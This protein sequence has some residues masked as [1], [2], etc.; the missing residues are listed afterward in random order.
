MGGDPP[1]VEEPRTRRKRSG[2]GSWE[3]PGWREGRRFSSPIATS[4]H[5]ILFQTLREIP[6][7]A[8]DYD[9]LVIG[10]G[11][12]GS[13]AALRLVEKG[14]S[15]GVV[16]AGRRWDDTTLP[17]TSW[18]LRRFLWFP[19]LGLRG[20]QRLTLLSDTMALS[21]VGVGGGS[22]VW[23]NVSYEPHDEAFSDPQWDGI[24]NWKEEL[25]P[26]YEQARRMLGV[27][28]NP[29]ETA[30]DTVIRRVAEA[31]GVEHTVEPTPV[32][33]YFG[34]PDVTVPDPY[35]GG[36][37]PTRTGC[38][39]CGGCMTGC[40][41]NA[42][43]RL[44]RSYLY[45]AEHHGVQV[46]PE[47]QVVDLRPLPD[48]GYEVVT[49]RPGAWI[50]RR[51]RAFTARQVVFSAGA[52]GTCKLLLELRDTGRLRELSSRLGRN[53]RTNS[54]A[55]V[56][57]TA[58][59]TDVD[60][61]RG[62]AISSSFQPDAHTH[63]EPVRYEKGSNAMGLLSTIMVDGGG[64][65]PRW[66]RFVAT[67]TTHPARFLRSLSVHH[68]SERTIILLVMQ[69][70]DNSLT[71]RRGRFGRLVTE[72]ERGKPSPTFI[73]IANESA[74]IAAELIGGDPGSSINEVLLDVPLTAHAIGGACIGDS[75]ERGVIDPYQ[76]MFGH[77]GLHVVDGAAISANLGVNP[78]LTI[79]AMSERA[80]AFWPNR[81]EPDPRPAA[82]E[83]YRRLDPVPP[84]PSSMGS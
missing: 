83:P 64:K 56:G 82:G 30:S 9:V 79:A 7:I 8:M 3:A 60:F 46:H 16:E 35:F 28:T 13:V 63:I 54:E 81:G 12:G 31:L 57:A 52:L 21:G 75:V 5:A 70:L 68:W 74:R 78:S 2:P 27:E 37:G 55:L 32:A 76:R 33:V 10:S 38:V 48:G 36:G 49:V 4:P 51:P 23:A 58:R 61:S 34:E 71:V 53:L 26:F 40:R 29:V 80:M 14:Y 24:T 18:Q 67:A 11:F 45:L 44:D 42:K 6:S 69:S 72:Q 41:H 22:L 50:R 1:E 84:P 77:P 17:T 73:P 59:S 65:M 47:H 20:I 19:R 15:V 43:N 62:V 66:L 25:A 39:L